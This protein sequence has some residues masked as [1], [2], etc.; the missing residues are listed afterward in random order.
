GQD[1]LGLLEKAARVARE[2]GAAPGLDDARTGDQRL[3]LILGEHERWQMESLRQRVADP[4]L[5]LD[6]NAAA[7]QVL[8]VAVDGAIRDLELAGDLGRGDRRA[9]A[10]ELDDLE[11]SIGAPHERDPPTRRAPERALEREGEAG[12]GAGAGTSRS[13]PPAI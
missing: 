7:D 9:H 6:G 5:A 8:D 4:R 2:G 1:A 11:Q 3:D 13:A 12:A 10:Q